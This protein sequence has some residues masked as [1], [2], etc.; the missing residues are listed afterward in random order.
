MQAKAELPAEERLISALVGEH[1]AADTRSQVP[2]HAA[3]GELDEKEIEVAVAEPRRHADRPVRHARHAARA[4]D[5]PGRDD[6]GL[7]GGRPPQKRRMTVAA[8]RA[9]LEREEADKLL[10]NDRLTKDAV[11]HAENNGIV[12][13]D[14]IDKVCARTMRGRLPR[15]RRLAARACSATCCR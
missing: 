14:E 10:D 6:E 9:A 3:R 12:F 8:A 13:L 1:A 7:F 2:P 15:R 11:A 5:Q 4:G